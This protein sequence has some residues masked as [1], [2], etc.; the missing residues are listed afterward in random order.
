MK[1]VFI[2]LIGFFTLAFSASCTRTVNQ[3]TSF[4]L[5]LPSDLGASKVGS[6]AVTAADLN[7]LIINI[8]GPGIS[9][10]IYFSWDSHDG[11]NTPPSSFTL[12]VPQGSSR[13]VQVL[14]VYKDGGDNAFYYGDIANL[15]TQSANMSVTIN[16]AALTSSV[17]EGQIA[18]RYINSLSGTGPTGRLTTKY[19]PPGRPSM[20]IDTSEIFGG[21]FRAFALDGA[22]LEYV[23]DNGESLFEGPVEAAA[24]INLTF[25]SIVNMPA[26]FRSKGS[27]T[28]ESRGE[29][30]MTLGW[31]AP[32]A[33]RGT[34]LAG[35]GVC[36]SGAPAYPEIQG[37]YIDDSGADI[38]LEWDLDA[39]IV[40]GLNTQES[41][42][43]D[44]LCASSGDRFVDYLSIDHMMLGNHDQPLA[45]KGPY[46]LKTHNDGYGI[47]REVFEVNYSSANG[48]Q[49][50]WDYLPGVITSGG[51]AGIDGSDVFWRANIN[52]SNGGGGDEEYRTDGGYNCAG[53]S[54]YGFQLLHSNAADVANLNEDVTLSSLPTGFNDAFNDG[55]ID[56]VM[57]PYANTSSGKKYYQAG[58]SYHSPQGGTPATVFEIVKLSGDLTTGLNAY[59]GECSTFLLR[60][61][62]GWLSNVDVTFTPDSGLE[63]FDDPDCPSPITS[64]NML[65]WF[66][67]GVLLYVKNTGSGA[68]SKNLIITDNIGGIADL[69]VNFNFDDIGTPTEQA[70]ILA[71]STIKKYGCYPLNILMRDI[72]NSSAMLPMGSTDSRDFDWPQGVS[73]LS[74]Y[75]FDPSCMGPPD[76]AAMTSIYT[77]Q[78]T[79]YDQVFFRYTGT[80]STLNLTPTIT[81]G[82]AVPFAGA[83][84]T[85]SSPGAPKRFGL[86]IPQNIPGYS[87]TDFTLQLQDASG[88]ETGATSSFNVTLGQ[89]SSQATFYYADSGG[90]CSCSSPEEILSPVTFAIGDSSKHLCYQTS[91]GGYNEGL[92]ATGTHSGVSI[93]GSTNFMVDP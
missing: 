53:L 91:S 30:N 43:T 18:G 69:P 82:S 19:T 5:Q 64:T 92:S 86:M 77:A 90:V 23:L 45:F 66:G 67:E 89:A 2:I 25:A 59:N 36:N 58:A 32:T 61:A 63:I 38:P 21:Y 11:A 3:K 10:P 75:T 41:E 39:F 46:K 81:T 93:Q 35:K 17:G 78:N 27:N 14:A 47:W 44:Y 22:Q 76:T 28:Y 87:C 20:I 34:V 16:V 4:Q 50:K 84:V 79:S 56:L 49:L 57:C 88:Y 55:R 60:G 37:A 31:F 70:L 33:I 68:V 9:S 24:G 29:S 72:S 6:M 74:F 71:P 7:H 12:D 26:Y 1:K 65:P 62:N 13:L 42:D 48:L 54:A 83:T 85:V 8:T 73:G 51:V 15:S 80:S 52:P 40:L